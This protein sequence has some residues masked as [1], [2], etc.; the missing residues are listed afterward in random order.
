MGMFK[1]KKKSGRY[2]WDNRSD[3]LHTNEEFVRDSI[4]KSNKVLLDF[5]ADMMRMNGTSL[6]EIDPEEQA[7][8][9]RYIHS[10]NE[11]CDMSINYAKQLDEIENGRNMRLK[12][13][14]E[15]EDRILAIL[16]NRNLKL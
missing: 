15:K 12:R 9:N 2:Q 6:Q 10:W 14:E 7:M 5:V 13:M 4:N 1:N 11:L 16:E 8:F 3:M